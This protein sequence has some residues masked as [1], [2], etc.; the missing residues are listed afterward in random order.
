MTEIT[1]D[2]SSFEMVL[3]DPD[4]IVADAGAAIDRVAGL[5]LD[6]LGV[7]VDEMKPTTRMRVTGLDPATIHLESGT[8]ENTKRPR[9]YSADVAAITFTKLCFEIAQRRDAAFGAPDLD[10]ELTHAERIAWDVQ[11]IGRVKAAG[12][13]LYLPKYRYDFR[14]RHGFSDAVDAAF[15]RLLDLATPTFGDIMAVSHGLTD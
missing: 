10:A 6:S 8:L 11:L 2:P 4:I 13:R 7:T 3:F 5:R 14:N 15:D 9:T 1:L 12:V